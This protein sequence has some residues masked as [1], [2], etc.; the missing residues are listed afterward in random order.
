MRGTGKLFFFTAAVLLAAVL[1]PG[2]SWSLEIAGVNVAEEV[3]LAESQEKLVLNGAGIRKKF[4]IKV[5]VGALYLPSRETTVDGIV[6]GGG[7]R[8]VVMHF[9]YKEVEAKK[10]TA[11][12]SDGFA[13]N[14]TPEE[15]K[16]L[17]ARLERFNS[18]FTTARK[19]D[20]YE[21]D[22]VAGKGTTVRFNGRELGRVEGDDFNRALLK[23]WLGKKP[24][25][26][27]LKK[28]WLG[29]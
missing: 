21:L 14:L 12:W 28:A 6:G 11:A 9:L 10:L 25:D 15:R 1:H 19:G 8:K 22:L 20:V 17:A 27:G 7:S 23:V 16:T 4:V 13:G 2:R 24:A 18:L 5:Y 3:T 26:N 29:N